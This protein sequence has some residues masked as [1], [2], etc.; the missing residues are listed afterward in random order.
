MEHDAEGNPMSQMNPVDPYQPVGPVAETATA[1][2]TNWVPPPPPPPTP[3]HRGEPN[4]WRWI[5][6]SFLVAM[7]AAGGTGIGVGWGLAKAL[8]TPTVVQSPI[9]IASPTTAPATGRL[10]AQ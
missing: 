2:E 6:V 1:P 7:I 8:R 10:D 3:P 5:V 4:L 9:A